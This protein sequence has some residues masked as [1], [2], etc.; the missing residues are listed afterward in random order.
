VRL[1][2]RRRRP[3]PAALVDDGSLRLVGSGRDPVRGEAAVLDD[4]AAA[5]HDPSSP[6]LVRQ[7]FELDDPVDRS[8]L[9]AALGETGY[10]VSTQPSTADAPTAASGPEQVVGRRT[11]VLTVLAAAQAR[12]R[13]TG[14]ETRLA[15][16]YLGWEALAPLQEREG[17]LR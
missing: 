16:R 5:G 4:I 13:M 17:P 15:C 6:V 14:L 10:K 3:G 11:Q 1:F 12:A 7:L 8:A 9:V 2:G